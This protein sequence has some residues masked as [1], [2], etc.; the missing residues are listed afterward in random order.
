MHVCQHM[1]P[2]GKSNSTEVRESCNVKL[3]DRKAAILKELQ[4]DI[5]RLQRLTPDTGQQQDTGLGVMRDAFPNGSFPVGAVHEFLY[6][7]PEDA[8]ATGGFI[9]GLLSALMGSGVVLW[10]S[11]SRSLFPPALKRFKLNPDHFIFLE[12][13]HE[14]DIL[15]AM[16]EA[17][18]CPA[19]SAVVGE[20]KELSFTASRRLQLAVEESRVTGFVLRHTEGQVNTT[21]CVSRWKI[22]SIP[23]D[24]VEDLPG[25]GHPK[26]RIE[27][28]R[29]RNGKTGTWEVEW[30]HD[31][32]AVSTMV[33]MQPAPSIKKAG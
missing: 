7:G 15:W 26:W 14:K 4:T 22:A 20:V 30:R 8:S 27:L 21:A 2:S 32:F 5:L 28:L 3:S 19:L 11:R 25:I 1:W 13:H 24:P 29:M 18:K 12:V 17:L 31:R 16:N 6:P 23:S 9:A 33:S 10:I